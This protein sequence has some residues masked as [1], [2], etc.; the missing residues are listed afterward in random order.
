L[1][2]FERMFDAFLTVS[3]AYDWRAGRI[4]MRMIGVLE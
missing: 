4:P 3:Y 1:G 2:P